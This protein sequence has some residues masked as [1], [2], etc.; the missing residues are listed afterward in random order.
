MPPKTVNKKSKNFNKKVQ[1]VVRRMAETKVVDYSASEVKIK[2]NEDSPY[3]QDMT[4]VSRGTHA[5]ERNGNEI[6]LSGVK[7]RIL[8]HNRNNEDTEVSTIRSMWVRIALIEQKNTNDTAMYEDFFRKGSNSYDFDAVTQQ[9]KFYLPIDTTN[10]KTLYQTT[11]KLGMSNSAHTNNY[12]S[13]KI[14]KK[15]RKINK[16]INFEESNVSN[17]AST[18]IYFV[19]WAGNNNLDATTD[20]TSRGMMEF[21]GLLSTYFK[22]F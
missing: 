14:L 10:R 22:D 12:V 9:E 15:Y 3:V 17:S 7:W 20:E 21:S 13:N 16:H 2:S 5:T 8:L 4:T 11:L 6:L 18:K 19:M 1:N